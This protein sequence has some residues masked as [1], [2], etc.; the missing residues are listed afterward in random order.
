MMRV[1]QGRNRGDRS[2]RSAVGS[3]QNNVWG[4]SISM[5][6]QREGQHIPENGLQLQADR[7]ADEAPMQMR[8][9]GSCECVESRGQRKQSGLSVWGTLAQFK[10][11]APN[12]KHRKPSAGRTILDGVFTV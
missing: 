4:H 12:I 7:H 1:H 11:I 5:G 3:L 2:V 6:I 9:E 8:K 10:T